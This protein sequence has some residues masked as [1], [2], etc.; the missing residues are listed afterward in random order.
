MSVLTDPTTYPI[1]AATA[2]QLN[3]VGGRGPQV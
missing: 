3:L 2:R 1:S